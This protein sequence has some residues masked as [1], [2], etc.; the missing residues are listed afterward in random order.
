LLENLNGRGHLED[1]SVSGKIILEWMLG[2][3][4]G[5]WGLDASGAG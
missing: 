4:V 1:L 3:R 5:G 2:S